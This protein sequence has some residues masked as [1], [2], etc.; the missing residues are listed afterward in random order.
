MA[1]KKLFIIFLFAPLFV[2]ASGAEVFRGEVIEV[3][4]EE[5]FRVAEMNLETFSQN[6]KIKIIDE[7]GKEKVIDL[8]NDYIKLKKGDKVFVENVRNSIEGRDTFI[9]K[10]K[11]R[12]TT[13]IYFLVVFIF[14][15]ILFGGM[16]GVRSVASLFLSFVA[17]GYILV[18]AI[19][20]GYSPVLISGAVATV[21]LFMAIYFTHGFNRESTAAFLGTVISVFITGILSYLG[22]EI[23][24]FTGLG[25]EEAM[26]LSL[27]GEISMD[28]AG[29][30]LG[31]IIIGALG[32]L[33]D[34]AVTQSIV[35]RE[36]YKLQ[37]DMKF[38][39]AYKRALS[40][41]KEHVGAMV[42]T[43][44]LAY[45]GASLPLILIFYKS[46]Y[47]ISLILSQEIFSVEIMRTVVGSIGLI[48]SVPLTTAFAVYLLRSRI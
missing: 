45:T 13:L 26:M 43:L 41:G 29:L 22:V 20:N 18:P 25:T 4:S 23:A 42:N 8:E 37:R 12:T 16:Q 35:V 33:D 30:L 28:F 2:L 48:L 1:I 46:E 15:V 32:V 39:D 5:N 34:V 21:I 24:Q 19:M 9:V 3:V 7:N 27:H 38:F 47:P 10:E 14:S 17:I 6:L 40:V 36:I 44:A 11:D 31:G